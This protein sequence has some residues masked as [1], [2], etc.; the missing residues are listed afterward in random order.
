MTRIALNRMGHSVQRQL[1]ESIGFSSPAHEE[2]QSRLMLYDH[3]G[4]RKYLT[5]AERRTFIE[6]A[7]RAK[8]EMETFCL[9]LAH[10]GARI[11][12]VLAL[13]P[14]RIDLSADVIIIESLKKRRQGVFR[15]LPVP[16]ELISRL[17]T[18]H[19]IASAQTDIEQ[20]WQRLW[21]WGRTTAWTRV[22]RVMREVGIAGPFAVP[23]GLRHAFAVA[24]VAEAQVPLNLMQK[25]LGH[26]R[27]DTTA[28]YA[29]AVGK[30]ERT[31]AARMW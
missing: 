20:M 24:G 14:A 15:S 22:K 13:T 27:L 12:E 16:T 7:K 29:N 6:G 4:N 21:P 8:P 2:Q 9:T 31:A 3:Q 18:V 17:N 26:A 23:K 5:P 28:I 1:A 11:S 10:T 25:W 30:E 19:S